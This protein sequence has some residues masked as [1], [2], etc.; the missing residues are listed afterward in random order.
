MIHLLYLA[1]NSGDYNR[2][3]HPHLKRVSFRCKEV[4]LFLQF[5]N[6][7]LEILNKLFLAFCRII[8]V[9]YNSTQNTII[10]PFKRSYIDTSATY[11]T[12]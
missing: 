1:P 3:D 11:L 7:G 8:T 4:D 10:V 2:E 5:F 12:K 6:R 9:P